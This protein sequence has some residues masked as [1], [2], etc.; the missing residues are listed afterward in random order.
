MGKTAVEDQPVDSQ[1][2]SAQGKSRKRAWMIGIVAVLGGVALFAGGYFL[3]TSSSD[4]SDAFA[5]GAVD[6]LALQQVIQLSATADAIVEDVRGAEDLTKAQEKGIELQTVA[7]SV[8]DS[9]SQIQ[10]E[11]LRAAATDLGDGYLDVSVGLITNNGGRVAQG[12]EKIS[13]GSQ[14]LTL[15]VNPDAEIDEGED[16]E[17]PADESPAEED[18][19]EDKPAEE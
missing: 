12:A 4:S 11:E 6:S 5:D 13:S 16:P 18:P 15:I 19:A 14:A 2:A 1:S 17:P 7:V 3:A 10:D 8:Q 9:A